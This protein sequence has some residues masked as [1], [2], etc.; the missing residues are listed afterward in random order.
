[1]DSEY[2]RIEEQSRKNLE[3][4]A[5]RA[6]EEELRQIAEHGDRRKGRRRNKDAGEE[7]EIVENG[8]GG[9]ARRDRPEVNGDVEGMGAAG[10]RRR[11]RAGDDDDDDD[12][13]RKSKILC[14]FLL[15]NT[16]P[17]RMFSTVGDTISTKKDVQY[18]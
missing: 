17:L 10:R 12:F 18:C 13:N 6:K 5:R 1:M 7:D 3:E 9:R 4:D 15:L 2:A 16:S 8:D 11:G 14:S